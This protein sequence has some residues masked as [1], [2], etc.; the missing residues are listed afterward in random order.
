MHALILFVLSAIQT[1]IF[2]VIG[3]FILEIHG[4]TLTYWLVLFSISCTA[5]VIGL[6][7]SSA[8][9]SAV[10][11]YILIPLLIIPQMVL[12]GL[13]FSFDKLNEIVSTKGKVPIVADI[14]ASRWG[15]EG[16]AVR[17][18]MNNEY[19]QK[20]YTFEKDELQA[21]DETLRH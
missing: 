9:N 16:V 15:Y 20:F 14:M 11:V 10:T 12:S 1:I 13:L 19:E 3:N 18:F 2:T 17:Q 6:N 5:N 21:K 7:I 8:F 4:M